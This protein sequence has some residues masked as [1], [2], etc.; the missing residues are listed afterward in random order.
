MEYKLGQSYSLRHPWA[1]HKPKHAIDLKGS[2]IAIT[3]FPRFEDDK[4][5][6]TRKI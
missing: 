3:V 2:I 6:L 1:S 5:S 4:E